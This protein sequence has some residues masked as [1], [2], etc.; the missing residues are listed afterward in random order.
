MKNCVIS[1]E[2]ITLSKGSFEVKAL[3]RVKI[4][5]IET[6]TQQGNLS[7]VTFTSRLNEITHTI[8]PEKIKICDIEIE[9]GAENR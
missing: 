8:I 5:N 1:L 7:D 3:M 6:G 2:E 4:I 9:K